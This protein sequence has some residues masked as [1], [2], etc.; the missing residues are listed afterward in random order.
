MD[1]DGEDYQNVAPVSFL[2]FVGKREKMVYG[3]G[4]FLVTGIQ[5]LEI[6]ALETLFYRKF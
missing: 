6:K 4:F 3:R 2:I 1:S 5:Y